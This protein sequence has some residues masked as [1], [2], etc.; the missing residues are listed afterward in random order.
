MQAGAQAMAAFAGNEG[1]KLKI[2]QSSS[3]SSSS[4]EAFRMKT[5]GQHALLQVGV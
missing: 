4:S 5:W 1:D 3:S 2:V